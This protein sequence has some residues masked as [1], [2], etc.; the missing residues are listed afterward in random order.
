MLT[1]G[2]LLRGKAKVTFTMPALED[3]EALFLV[4]DFNN[5]S[6]TAHLMERGADGA[7]SLT[8]PLEPGSYEFRYYDN[9]NQWHNDWAADSYVPNQYGGDNSIVTVEAAARKTAARKAASANGEAAPKRAPRKKK[10]E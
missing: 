10:A 4:G 1:K 8:V 9:K 5:W 3:V 2:K 6:I 7:W